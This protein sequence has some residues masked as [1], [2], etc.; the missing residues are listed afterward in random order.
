ME[1]KKPSITVDGAIVK[2][3]NI[4]LIKRKN[5]PYKNCWALPGGFVEYGESYEQAA[6]REGKEETNLDLT[7]KSQFMAFSSPG[8]DKRF[9]TATL[10]FV[11]EGIGIAE[12]KDDAKSAKWF[13]KNEIK[14]LNIAFDHKEIIKRYLKYKKFL[15][16]KNSSF[17]E[18]G[19]F[20]LNG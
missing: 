20:L 9:H 1:Y 5:N 7:L 6:K 2:N 13:S 18:I 8:R 4:L 16:K 15:K 12:G 17:K 3:N 19:K 10:V 11:A 14:S